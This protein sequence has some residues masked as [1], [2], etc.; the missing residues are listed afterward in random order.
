MTADIINLRLARKRKARDSADA[1]AANN[2]IRFGRSKAERRQTEARSER[3]QAMLDGHRLDIPH[4]AG[5][6]SPQRDDG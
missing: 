6:T 3:E 1:E 2:R 5:K 4:P